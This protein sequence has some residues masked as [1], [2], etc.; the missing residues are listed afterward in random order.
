M[1]PRQLRRFLFREIHQIRGAA[2]RL[3]GNG[4]VAQFS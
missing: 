3:P 4:T 1:V 2:L